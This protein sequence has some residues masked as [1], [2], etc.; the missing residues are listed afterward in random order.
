M[1]NQSQDVE[2]R[3]RATNFT[4][5]TTDKVV[6]ALK[7]MTKAQDA[8]IESAKKGTTTVA[9][10]EASYTKL[11]NAAKAL[12]AQQS[13]TKLYEAQT[14]T[15]TELE[16]KLE[17][18]RKAQQDYANSLN[19]GEERTKAQQ[20]ELNRLGK[21][22]ASV[23][24]QYERAQARVETT[25]Q[26]LAQ[27]G[28]TASNLAESQQKIVAAVNQAN[29]ALERQ[30]NAINTA[31][32]DA[33]RRKA[34]ADAIAQRELQVKVDNQFAQAERDVAAALA[35]ERAAQIAANQA[36]A[37][38]QRERQVEVDVLFA[39]AQR[40][41]TEEL[42]KKTAALRAQQQALQNAADAAERMSRSSVVTARGSTPVITPQL[43]QQIRDIQN[44]ADAAVRSI[45]GIEAAVGRLETRVTQIRG[46]VR[47]YR[48]ALEDARRTQAALLAVAGQVDTYQNQIAALRAARYEYT[49]N[50]TAVN[51]LIAAMRAG[52][53]GDDITT[54][55]AAAQRTLQQSATALGNLMT[56]SRQTQ[57]A[58]REAGVDTAQLGAAE[59]RL[60][61]QTNRATQALNSLN[62]A[63]RRNGAAAEQSGSRILSFFGGDGGR[64]TLSYAQRLR[65]ELLSLAAGFVG[66][67]AA[68]ELAK[69]TLD[70]YNETQAIM[71]RLL[72]VNNGD[73]RAAVADYKYLQAATDRIGVSFAKVAPAF[74]KFAIAAKQAGMNSQQTR[75]IFE[76][77]AQAT[78]KLGLSGIES[79]RVFKAIEQM[80]NKGKVSA[81][82]LSQQLGDAL[83]GAYNLFAKAAGMTTQDFAKAMEQGQIAPSLLVKV[84]K[85]LKE[86]YGTVNNGVENLSQSQA[87]FDN[88]F[89]RFL[90]NT[91][92][93]GFVQAYQQLLNKLSTM[94]NDGTA[95]KFAT[96]LSQ[97]F[98]SVLNVMEFVI[99]NFDSLKRVIEA[100]IAVKI[101]GWLFSLPAAFV[102]V[103]NEVIALQGAMVALNAWMVRAEGAAALS[104][105][106]GTGGVAGVVA[107][108][109]PLVLNLAKAFIF[110]G[111]STVVLAA[112]YA[113]YQATS[114][115][116]DLADNGIRERIVAATN[117]ATKAFEDAAAARKKLDENTDKEQ[118]ANLKAQYDKLSKIAVDK[119]KEQA[120]LVAQAQADG[121]NFDA[122]TNF[123]LDQQKKREAAATG[124]QNAGDTPFPGNPDDSVAKLAALKKALAVEDKK[125][126]RAMKE[127][128]L[129]TAKEELDER[130]A[131]IKEPFEEL[132]AQ[133]KGSITDEAKYQEAMKAID[134]S[135]A[136]AV[137]A[138]RAKFMNEQAAKNK[139]E[140]ERRVRLAQ[141]IK[142][143][144]DG[145]EADIA[146]KNAKA[147][148]T[149]PYE[150][151]RAAAI[152]KVSHAYD[153]LN[154]RIMAEKKVA[155][156]Q[157]A[158]DQARLELLKKQREVLEGE[159]QDRNEAN[160]LAEEFNAKQTILQNRL[161]EIK[162]LY[163]SGKISS[164]QFLDRT[165]YAVATLGPGVE[166]AGQA[167]L[168]FA[169]RVKSVLDP[170]AYSNL[171][172]TVRAGM[173]KSDVDASLAVNNLNAQQTTLNQI[174][175]QQQR[176]IDIITAKRKL[177]IIDAQQEAAEL[178]KNA[179]DYKD[180][181]TANVDEMLRLLQTARDMGAISADAFNKAA[182]GANLLKL[183]TQNAHAAS[184]DLDKTIVNSIATNGVTAF[185]SLAEQI[186]KVATGAESIGEGFRG[187]LSAIG[188]FFAQLLMDIAQAIIKQLILN[189][190]VRALGASSGVGGAAVAAGGT[191]AAAGAHRG[192]VMG[193]SR[194]FTRSMAAD[195]FTN[196]V[197]YHTGGIVGLAPNEVPAVLQKNEE[198]LTRNDPRHVLNGGKAAAPA[199]GGAGN[200]FV[201][202]DDRARVPE[203]MSSSEGEKVTLVHL[204]KN[205]AT[206]KQWLR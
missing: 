184:S 173:A 168:D 61:D 195:V 30:E 202:V 38:K 5:Q 115:L 98:V 117:A 26:R 69:K 206:L 158:A 3:I 72:V 62:D 74:S 118:Q 94:L 56:A 127:Q 128:R 145:I 35:A 189:A 122:K 86:T 183:N 185:Q 154:L 58:L 136:K 161:A 80:F 64:T 77:F 2:L 44:P 87:R 113:A 89:N 146:N 123:A 135:E 39:Q 23:E 92:N 133:Q 176:D 138:E 55:L 134:V 178:N 104:A 182:A 90:N 9:Q 112:G 27:F 25:S 190:L 152:A 204:K 83:P 15:L 53:G 24:K 54:R 8:Q 50:R 181:I 95:D 40:Q 20:A 79:E 124:N 187:A 97:A 140:G 137:A 103:R 60:V 21:A 11:E 96:Q 199:D 13:L 18:A 167:A 165:N 51:N 205:I 70:A 12:L 169:A 188:A 85:E 186:A 159:N 19:P 75:Y 10:L 76:G 71:N 193:Q 45:D 17:A 84:A 109:T 164:Q 129:R 114:A 29:A 34:Q 131:I 32:A 143:K 22:L 148:R 106:L 150:E 78:S 42:N 132:R 120:R 191:V 162:T 52:T 139:T 116:L 73:M 101:I 88:A 41:A 203:A 157:A 59:Q 171:V 111:K 108:L 121:V 81:E 156:E 36:A 46:P 91:A 141:E 33:A 170:V 1:A 99:D 130:L 102:A 163:D 28:I 149:R 201:L 31:D 200:R 4:K 63:Y 144:L 48:G 49:Q 57:A 119:A 7:E 151:R 126:D 174:L 16:A 196:A 107:R 14:A 179:A 177:G 43:S 100:V 166:E 66:L 125:S 65:G 110:L 105:A 147:D 153:E 197:R 142:D 160:I 192:G 198:V 68:I 82:E 93:G 172:S 37:D 180:R 67:N 47:D 155:P 194:T 6:D 175:E